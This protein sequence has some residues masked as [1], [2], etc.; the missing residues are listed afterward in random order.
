MG[1]GVAG[2]EEL[3]EAGAVAFPLAGAVELLDAGAVALPEGAVVFAFGGQGAGAGVVV[4]TGSASASA[5]ISSTFALISALLSAS[6]FF[7]SSVLPFV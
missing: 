7:S 4:F 2:A 1:A 6:S 3:P 5:E